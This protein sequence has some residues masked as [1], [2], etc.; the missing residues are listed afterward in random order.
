MKRIRSPTSTR[1]FNVIMSRGKW[2]KRFLCRSNDFKF[3]SRAIL[4]G[5][6]SIKL[7][8]KVSA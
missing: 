7:S 2:R 5:S 4:V 6:I 1:F 3:D 8:H